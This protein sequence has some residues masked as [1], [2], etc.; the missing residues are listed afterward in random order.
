MADELIDVS[1]DWAKRAYVD[2]AKYKAMYEPPIKDPAK[3]WGE[4][5]D[6]GLVHRLVLGV[7]DIGALGPLRADVDQVIGHRFLPP[8]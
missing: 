3:F 8:A 7:V 4:I 5:L 2:D 6:R 1:A